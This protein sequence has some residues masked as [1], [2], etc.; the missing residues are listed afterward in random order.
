[1]VNN[2]IYERNKAGN[3]V[4]GDY[5]DTKLIRLLS[6][7][8]NF[9]SWWNNIESFRKVCQIEQQTQ[10]FILLG[11]WNIRQLIPPPGGALSLASGSNMAAQDKQKVSLYSKIEQ[12]LLL[13]SHQKRTNYKDHAGVFERFHQRCQRNIHNVG[14]SLWTPNRG[15]GEFNVLDI[16]AML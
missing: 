11:W 6:L 12:T 2:S 16:E 7:S 13:Y 10:A 14:C 9:H 5:I 8:S 1:M 4:E 15:Q 3:E